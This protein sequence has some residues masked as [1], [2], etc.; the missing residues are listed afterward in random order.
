M[1]ELQLPVTLRALAR[2]SFSKITSLLVSCNKKKAKINA[3]PENIPATKRGKWV[4]FFPKIAP[5]AGPKMKPAEFKAS[6]QE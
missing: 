1:F 3:I 2:I 5:K 6:K 4:P